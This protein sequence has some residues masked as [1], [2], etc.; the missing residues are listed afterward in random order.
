MAVRKSTLGFPADRLAGF[1]HET[2]V[3]ELQGPVRKV[4]RVNHWDRYNAI[5]RLLTQLSPLE[6]V[7]GFASLSVHIIYSIHPL[8][9]GKSSSVMAD[10]CLVIGED[11]PDDISDVGNTTVETQ[12][13]GDVFEDLSVVTHDSH[14]V[15][16]VG[17]IDKAPAQDFIPSEIE[18][19]AAR[20]L[21]HAYQRRQV[22]RQRGVTESPRLQ[23]ELSRI[24]SLCLEEAQHLQWPSQGR[25]YRK[26]YLGAL[27]HILLCLEEIHKHAYAVKTEARER[28]KVAKNLE[29]EELGRLQTVLR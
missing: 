25:I 1:C 12:D 26:I 29:L 18:K 9:K 10:D 28:M 13:E 4:K 5:P 20:I 11:R 27:P 6:S 17:S 23:M 21:L 24:F 2:G 22:A 3:F 8:F 15:T 19:Q 7:R 14:I 16:D